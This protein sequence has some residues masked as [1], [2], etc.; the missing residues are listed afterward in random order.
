MKAPLAARAVVIGAGIGG[1]TAAKAIAPYFAQVL[2]LERDALPDEPSA[3][4]GVPQG[5]QMHGL[6]PG[7]LI[8]LETLFPGF[9]ADLESAGAARVR[10]VQDFRIERPGY[11]PFP[12]RD[13]GYDIFSLSRPLLER[14]CRRRLEAE[15]NVEVR[16][17]CRVVGLTPTQTR[18]P[19][20]CG[21]EIREPDGGSR[22]IAADL[23][24]DASGRGSP[25]LAFLETMGLRKP[26]ETEIKVGIAYASVQLELPN[27]P[28]DW[29]MLVHAARLPYT[30]KCAFIQPIEQGRWIA[31]LGGAQEEAPPGDI[32]GFLAFARTL[33]TPTFYEVIKD[34]MLVGG[35]DRY[36]I[37]CSLRRDFGQGFPRGLVPVANSICRFNPIFGQGMSV[38]A[39]EAVALGRLLADRRLASD[40][41]DGLSDAF[42]S[43]IREVIDAAWSSV[44]SNVAKTAD[45]AELAKKVQYAACLVE[46]MARDAG[47]HKLVYE[48]ISLLKPYSSLRDP[49]LVSRVEAI[50]PATARQLIA[51]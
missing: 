35:I 13:F 29:S 21:V 39:M 40:P 8:A 10:C 20:V 12:Q 2:V 1:L 38:A 49:E 36:Q 22:A 17:R 18:P 41:L 19:A 46:L 34:A 42:L 4:A 43:D 26:E 28:D 14:L 3:R 30:T 11:D 5:R 24:I 27:P 9:R 25:T 47:V 51:A 15:P 7:G 32:E 23:V 6:L 37:D 31:S 48:V 16:P 44:A 45:P 33:R 50:D